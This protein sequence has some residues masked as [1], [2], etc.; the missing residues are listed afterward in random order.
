MIS[1][2]EE[3][4]I[5]SVGYPGV[6]SVLES[7][8]YFNIA[9]NWK[10]NLMRED[11]AREHLSENE[12]H[13]IAENFNSVFKILDGPDRERGSSEKFGKNEYF[14]F[15]SNLKEISKGGYES[16][17]VIEK[18]LQMKEC[19]EEIEKF[20]KCIKDSHPTLFI[21]SDTEGDGI[22]LDIGFK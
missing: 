9:S 10:K 4:S 6:I 13:I 3:N 7:T 20:K 16:L 12:E 19:E 21:E 15:R 18:M 11:F 8:L 17:L 22:T 5:L 2:L 1:K 14:E